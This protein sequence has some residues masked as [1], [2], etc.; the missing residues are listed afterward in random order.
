MVIGYRLDSAG[1]K[2]YTS[3]AIK[4]NS[5]NAGR[6]EGIECSVWKW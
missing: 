6:G 5:E 4:T 2:L 3:I 1:I